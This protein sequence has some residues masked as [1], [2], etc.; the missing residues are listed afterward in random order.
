MHKDCLPEITAYQDPAFFLSILKGEEGYERLLY[1]SFINFTWIPDAEYKLN[2]DFD[3]F[4]LYKNYELETLNIIQGWELLSPNDPY[5]FM[6]NFIIRK[7]QQGYLITGRF[8]EFYISHKC[9]YNT[10]HYNGQFYLTDVDTENKFFA[11]VGTDINKPYGEYKI[12]FDELTTAINDSITNVFEKEELTNFISIIKSKKV[13]H[14]FSLERVYKYIFL[15][16]NIDTDTAYLHGFDAVEYLLD[17]FENEHKSEYVTLIYEHA[18]LMYDRLKYMASNPVLSNL[19]KEADE[20]K[21]IIDIFDDQGLLSGCDLHITQKKLRE[22]IKKE[23][24]IISKVYDKLGEAINE[25]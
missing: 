1:S 15:L 10:E 5:N 19:L 8:D 14:V 6:V 9:R 22:I 2:I 17:H 13:N 11:A 25:F 18:K 16:L 21:E 23:R 20:Y 12:T 4:E 3:P 24:L 7:L